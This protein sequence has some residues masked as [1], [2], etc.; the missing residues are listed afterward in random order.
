MKLDVAPAIKSLNRSIP[1]PAA[2]FIFIMIVGSVRFAPGNCQA[3]QR[4]ISQEYIDTVIQQAFYRFHN[5]AEDVSSDYRRQRE[6]I[7]H[8][9]NV[10]SRLRDLAKS[11][12]NGKYIL[13]KVSELEQHILLEERDLLLKKMKKGQQGKNALIDRFNTEIGKPRPDFAALV[14]IHE[15]MLDIDVRKANEIA[16]SINQRNSNVSREV[17]YTIEKAL[18]TGDFEQARTELQYCEGNR[19]LLNV[20]RARCARFEQQLAARS[21]AR[22]RQASLEQQISEIESLVAENSLGEVWTHIRHVQA[23]LSEMKSEISGRRKSDYSRRLAR[24]IDAI[25]HKEDSLV[26]LNINILKRRGIDPAIEFMERALRVHGLSRSRISVVD[27][28]ILSVVTPEDRARRNSIQRDLMALNLSDDM[29]NGSLS[30]ASAKAIAQ[31]RAQAIRDSLRAIEEEKARRE[32]AEQARLAEIERKREEKLKKKRKKALKK[33]IRIYAL[34]ERDRVKRA[35]RRFK[36][37]RDDLA[38]Y[39]PDAHELLEQ[40]IA[41][42]YRSR[43]QPDAPEQRQTEGATVALVERKSSSGSHETRGASR[44][45]SRPSRQE[46]IQRE[47]EGLIIKIYGLLEEGNI[48]EAHSLF[49]MKQSYLK[50]NVGTEP[51]VM[52]E[53]T[54]SQARKYADASGRNGSRSSRGAERSSSAPVFQNAAAQ[55]QARDDYDSQRAQ[56]V[57]SSI[58]TLLE[59][60][61][62]KEAYERFQRFRTPLSRHAEPEVF[63]MLENTIQTTYGNYRGR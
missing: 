47:T 31:K 5:A 19:G 9:K 7:A 43:N 11:D 57:I 37:V 32:A 62:V 59:N 34:L 21:S 15:N 16:A 52:L 33:T 45:S 6:A 38:L 29:T 54:V 18:I 39:A 25:D 42:A 48:E 46:D 22:S 13:W 3:A 14:G 53:R 17:M 63:R 60:N 23:Q 40:T 12:P 10:C 58:Y 56:E 26:A 61:Q 49:T 28:A 41:D 24:M 36:R 27:S 35:Y 8:A 50:S 55:T 20:S 44:T 1:F 2:V 51:Y 4:Y 30:L